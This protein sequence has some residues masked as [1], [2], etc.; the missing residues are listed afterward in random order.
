MLAK[1]GWKQGKGLGT[2]EDGMTEHIKMVKKA[3]NAGIGVEKDTPSKNWLSTSV[4]YDS[5]LARLNQ[6][7]GNNSN[8]NEAEASKGMLEHAP[9]N[10]FILRGAAYRTNIMIR[11]SPK[12]GKNEKGDRFG[13]TKSY[14]QP[15][16]NKV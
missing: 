3:D 7:Y 8:N 13:A 14:S 5:V 15:G 1:M 9:H 12:K 6:A 4:A 16:H 10:Q 2:N 11:N